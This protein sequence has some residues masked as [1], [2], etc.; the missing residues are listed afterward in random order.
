MP[1][2]ICVLGLGYVGLPTACMFAVQGHKV[3]GVD[4]KPGL[5]E[6]IGKG[7]VHIEEA[8][9]KTMLQAAINSQNL[10]TRPTV[11]PADV[12]IISVPTPLTSDKRADLT[13]VE[14]AGRSIAPVLAPQNLVILESTVPPGT[15]AGM[16]CTIL[17]ESKLKPGVD[18]HVAHSPERVLPGNVF[19]ELVTNDRV[20]GGITKPCAEKARDLYK[21]FVEGEIFLTD[22]TTAEMVKLTE[23]T[24][25]DVNIALANELAQLAAENGADIFEIVSLA[26]RHSRVKVHQPGPGVGG[27][28]IPVD[29]WFIVERSKDAGNLIRYARKINDSAPDRIAAIVED[30]VGG[31]NG[32]KISIWGVAYKGNVDDTRETPAL[33]IIADLQSKNYR[34]GVFDF[35]VRNFTCELDSLEQS[36]TGAD[37]I[38]LLT[39]HK[40]FKYLDPHVIGKKMRKRVVI[41]T[42][43]CLDS[44]KWKEAG[45]DFYLFRKKM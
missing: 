44:A 12:F 4:V 19:S 28:C 26:N 11:E 10:V 8:G 39:D 33:H 15:T 30:I 29:P 25:R 31:N 43:N 35:H 24:F 13:C 17:A 14:K 37:A 18:F 27:H 7:E 20:V 23:N 36:V 6:A 5:V 42:R 2:K 34:L 41:D 16:L 3:V 9:L 40:E 22:A 1:K 32:A 21:A 45:F 38:L